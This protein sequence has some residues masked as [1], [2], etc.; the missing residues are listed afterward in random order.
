[1][2]TSLRQTAL[3]FHHLTHD[4][5]A[6]SRAILC[7]RKYASTTLGEMNMVPKQTQTFSVQNNIFAKD[8]SILNDT[9]GRY[10]D[11]LRISITERCNLRCEYCMPE[12]GVELMPDECSL[13]RYEI[14]KIMKTFVN[15]GVTKIRITGGEPLVRRDVVDIIQDANDLRDLGLKKIAVTTNGIMLGSMMS[16]LVSAGLDAVNISLD[17]MDPKKFQR[18]TRRGG[19]KRVLRSIDAA[20]EAGLTVKVNSVVMRDLNDSEIM[21]LV[22]LTKKK[23]VEVRFIEFMPFSSNKWDNDKFVSFKE[24]RDIIERHHTLKRQDDAPNETSKT[25]RIKDWPGRVGFITS[26]SD[27]FC[28]TC[29]RV[30]ITA[31]GNLKVCLFGSAEVSL[32]DAIRKGLPDAQ[33]RHIIAEAIYNK[34]ARHAGMNILSDEAKKGN[35]RSMIRIGG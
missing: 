30:R 1:M 32:R 2:R 7:S 12:E 28:S 15:A 33:L 19:L 17:T 24:M 27:H 13:T 35:N 22:S 21:D 4:W 14:K 6:Y 25:F 3:F 11:Y 18:I 10:H 8:N 5:S 9:F 23:N 20:A 26:M 34:K 29:N 31:D 16:K